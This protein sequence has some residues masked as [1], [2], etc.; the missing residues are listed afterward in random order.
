[1]SCYRRRANMFS[2]GKAP[3]RTYSKSHCLKTAWLFLVYK[4]QWTENLLLLC[5]WDYFI[6]NKNRLEPAEV[7]ILPSRCWWQQIDWSYYAASWTFG[8]VALRNSNKKVSLCIKSCMPLL[9]GRLSPWWLPFFY[10]FKN[11]G[12]ALGLRFRFS[13]RVM[14]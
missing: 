6:G 7:S 11:L 5:I 10:F 12:L 2:K 9:F 13:V 8:L 14:V 4:G 1:M 3:W